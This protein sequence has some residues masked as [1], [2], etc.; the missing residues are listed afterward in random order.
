MR[1]FLD[2]KDIAYSVVEVNPMS[3]AELD[4]TDYRKVP[5]ARIDGNEVNMT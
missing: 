5:V 3:K 1:A 4:F 2:F